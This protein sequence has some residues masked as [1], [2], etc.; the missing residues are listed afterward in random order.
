MLKLVRA[1][2]Y[3]EFSDYRG[4]RVAEVEAEPLS[5]EFIRRLRD[6][7]FFFDGTARLQFTDGTVKYVPIQETNVALLN[8]LLEVLE[9]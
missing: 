7:E 1:T 4:Y 5:R 2:V 9:A 3:G 6:S 8:N